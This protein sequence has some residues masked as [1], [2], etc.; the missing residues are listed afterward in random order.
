[1]LGIYFWLRLG[2][3]AHFSWLA[4]V[5]L[6][7]LVFYLVLISATFATRFAL[8]QGHPT[9]RPVL[10]HGP[11][12]LTYAQVFGWQAHGHNE[13]EIG[14]VLL[15]QPGRDAGFILVLSLQ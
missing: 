8:L 9:C 3:D 6:G 11:R 13:S 14:L 10:K 1:M 4:S 12:S 15:R 7:L 5:R 2:L